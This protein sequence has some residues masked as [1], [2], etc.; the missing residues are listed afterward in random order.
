MITVSVLVPVMMP[1]VPHPG[2][3][4]RNCSRPSRPSRLGG[5]SCHNRAV[6]AAPVQWTGPRRDTPNSRRAF[7]VREQTVGHGAIQQDGDY[8]PVQPPRIAFE[9]VVAGEGA[10]DIAIGLEDVLLLQPDRTSGLPPAR[11]RSP[12][13]TAAVRRWRR[14]AARPRE[15]PPCC[16]P[17][18]QTTAHPGRILSAHFATPL[19]PR[20]APGD[21]EP[22]C[23]ILGSTR[24]RAPA[25]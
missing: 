10:L 18:P 24:Q 6:A 17:G 25:L 2:G 15:A 21:H 20:T 22:G 23:R 13:P 9:P 1:V 3:G 14:R 4:T 8:S 19:L 11:R 5:N 12:E 16:A 7:T